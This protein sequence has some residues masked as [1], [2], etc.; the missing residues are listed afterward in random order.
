M[1][2]LTRFRPLDIMGIAKLLCVE[3]QDDFEE[4]IVEIVAK[5]STLSRRR[6]REL[7]KLA[8]QIAKANSDLFGGESD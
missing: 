8:E 5:F 2:Y 6:R 1:G 3:P 4:F 7:L